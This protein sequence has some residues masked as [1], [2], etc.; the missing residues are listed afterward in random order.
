MV[1]RKLSVRTMIL[2]AILGAWAIVL[3][4]FDFPILP[5]APFLKIDFSDLMAFIGML[6]YGPVGLITVAGIRDLINY[7]TSGGQAGLPIGVIMSFMA[8]L[9]MFL[10][11]HYILKFTSTKQ[12]MAKTISLSLSLTTALVLTMAIF[13]Y[14]VALPIYTTVLNFPIND[15]FDYVLSIIVPF[16]LIKGII[17]SIGQIIVLRSIVPILEKR[18]ILYPNYQETIKLPHSIQSSE[19]H[20]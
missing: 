7:I 5:A 9:V 8:T 14:Y 20:A 15:F 4:F 1:K 6:T 3:R 17:L 10:P 16:N 19:S 11:T 13:N 2:L 18:Q 12:S